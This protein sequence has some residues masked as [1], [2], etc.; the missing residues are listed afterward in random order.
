MDSVELQDKSA[1]RVVDSVSDDLMV[2][3]CQQR[4]RADKVGHIAR[5]CNGGGFRGG[6]GG[7][8]RGGMAPRRVAPTNP[9]GTPVKC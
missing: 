1:T 3:D 7:G 9:D 8:P 6:F 2:L 5:A 4:P